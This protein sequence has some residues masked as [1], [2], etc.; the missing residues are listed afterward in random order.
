[1]HL[2]NVE[3]ALEAQSTYTDILPK[4]IKVE[5]T[6]SLGNIPQAPSCLY[7]PRRD[8]FFCVISLP[9]VYSSISDQSIINDNPPST[10]D[11]KSS[12]TLTH[13]AFGG[14]PSNHPASASAKQLE[15]PTLVGNLSIYLYKTC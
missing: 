3:L 10:I 1:M 12:L 14:C 7:L 2:A 8:S 13:I 4:Y 6:L 15:T 11:D 5:E 9:T